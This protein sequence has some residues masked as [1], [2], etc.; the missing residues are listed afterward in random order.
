MGDMAEKFWMRMERKSME[1]LVSFIIPV[2]G[3][4][5]HLKLSLE[6]VLKQPKSQVILVDYSCPENSA[7]WAEETFQEKYPNLKTIRCSYEKYFN[8][9]KARNIGA[10]RAKGEFLCFLDCDMVL[11]ENF[12]E[13]C[14]PYLDG[15]SFVGF[16]KDSENGYG[17][18]IMVPAEVFKEIGGYDEELGGWGY[19]D[20]D[21][22]DKVKRILLKTPIPNKLAYHIPHGDKERTQN[23]EEKNR[24]TSWAANKQKC[25]RR[26]NILPPVGSTILLP[27]DFHFIWI[28]PKRYERMEEN[29]N[30]WYKHH[31]NWNFNFWTDQKD[32][33][34]SGCTIRNI[35]D[36]F[37]FTRQ[38]LYEKLSI[39]VFKSYVL[40]LEIIRQFGGIYLDVD[41]LCKQNIENAI[42]GLMG[43]TAFCTN[44][45]TNCIF[46][47]TKNSSWIE[48]MLALINE[49]PKSGV[50]VMTRIT[51]N[52]P[53]IHVFE[54][55]VFYPDREICPQQKTDL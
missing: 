26:S 28:G 55:W 7:R 6:S 34:P 18:T 9:S 48:T 2:M 16:E 41:F 15:E 5:E 21:F 17:G 1:Y 54:D 45:V 43:F 30:S 44:H 39:P 22:R 35:R 25:I 52:F 11:S 53:E 47:A 31:E 27:N 20:T 10:W 50:E 51:K 38:D 33:V 4:L 13:S 8:L 3:R 40:R 19:E 29:I 36:L 24:W 32:L 14:L 46:G 23:Y 12:I 42:K 37:P 49:E